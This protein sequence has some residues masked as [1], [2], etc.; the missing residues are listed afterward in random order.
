MKSQVLVAALGLI[1]SANAHPAAALEARVAGTPI[2]YG[3]GTT[4]GAGGKETTVTTCA[5]LITAVAKKDTSKK[6]VYIDGVLNGCGIVDGKQGSS[7]IC[8]GKR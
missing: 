6:V 7:H 8:F 4:G 3:A 2:G 5:A 1:S